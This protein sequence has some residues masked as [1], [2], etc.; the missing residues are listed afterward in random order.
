MGKNLHPSIL[1]YWERALRGHSNVNSFERLSYSDDYI[2]RIQRKRSQDMIILASDAYRFGLSDFFTRNEVIANGTMIYLARPES[3]YS[4]DVADAAKQEE[5]TIGK[6]KE[7][8]G[9]LN[10]D[11]H[12]TWESEDRKDKREWAK[13]N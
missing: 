6:L 5:V 9:A 7:I 10:L 8:L 2:Y 1:P 11:R 3:D 4:L 12:W 13:K